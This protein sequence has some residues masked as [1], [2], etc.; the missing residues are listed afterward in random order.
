MLFL[1]KK[2]LFSKFQSNRSMEVF[3]I[4]RNDS[5][6]GKYFSENFGS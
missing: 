2:K 4:T 6:V 5:E 3:K 1:S